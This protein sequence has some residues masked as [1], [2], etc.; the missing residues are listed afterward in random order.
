MTT[1][2]N[3]REARRLDRLARY[4]SSASWFAIGYAAASGKYYDENDFA[5][6]VVTK[7]NEYDNGGTFLP[8]VPD[9][10]SDWSNR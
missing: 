8:S 6:Y 5:N 7:V 10:F 2:N 1:T 3:S 4:Q 9:M